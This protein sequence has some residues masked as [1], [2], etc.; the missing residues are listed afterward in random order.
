MTE[1]AGV[2]NKRI[3][4]NGGLEVY[5]KLNAGESV[6]IETTTGKVKG[7]PYRFYDSAAEPVEISGNWRVDF[8]TGGPTLPEPKELSKLIS[9]TDFG[10]D[11]VKDFSGTA[12][13]SISFNKPAGKADAYSLNL[14][15]VLNSVKVTLNGK[16]VGT[17]IGTDFS[18]D[19]DKSLVKPVNTLELEVSN[20][21]A[22]RIAYLDRNNIEW[23]KFYN[24]NMAARLRKNNNNGIFDASAWKPMDAGL[25]GP[26]TITPLSKK[27]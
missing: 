25:I 6:I 9:W 16:E 2:A 10:G 3:A 23:K 5:L 24:V 7:Q 20:L 21:M 12:K 14:G 18:I 19:I 27:K 11:D 26:V 13:Y 1:K 8:I 22:N 4:G 15:R 17:L